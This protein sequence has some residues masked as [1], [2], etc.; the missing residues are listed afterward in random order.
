MSIYNDG[1]ILFFLNDCLTPEQLKVTDE[2]TLIGVASAL[3]IEYNQPKPVTIT[4]SF[5]DFV[6]KSDTNFLN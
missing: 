5:S 4:G 3:H 1:Y 6:P 2:F